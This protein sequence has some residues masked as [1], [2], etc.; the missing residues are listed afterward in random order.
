MT[1]KVVIFGSTGGSGK[2]ALVNA[3][4][5]G[6]TVTVLV[7]DSSK[8][9]SLGP[10][11][12][13]KIRIVEGNI[14]DTEKVKEVIEGQ[15]VVVS[16]IGG[17]MDFSNPLKPT[18][19]DPTICMDAITNIISAISTAANPPTRLI[20]LSTTGISNSRDIPLLFLPLY[21]WMLAVPHEDKK[22]MEEAIVEAG[23]KGIIKEWII[24]RP[25]LLT[26]GEKTGNYQVG[27]GIIGYLI[28]RE[29][30]GDFVTKNLESHEWVGKYPVL[31]N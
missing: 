5:A 19:S 24:V 28:S 25:G 22:K 16:A 15:Q 17:A 7:R 10:E 13:A 12:K 27:E 23:E 11:N 1:L 31:V 9:D 18:L 8:L 14:K 3:I 21:H 26:N 4:E 20:A 29:D 30:V 2:A 6:H